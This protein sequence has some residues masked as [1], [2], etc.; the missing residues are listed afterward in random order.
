MEPETKSRPPYSEHHT[1]WKTGRGS[2]LTDSESARSK[3]VVMTYG[4]VHALHAQLWSE[5]TTLLHVHHGITGSEGTLRN[6]FPV[7]LP[8]Q[9]PVSLSV[10]VTLLYPITTVV[11]A[12]SRWLENEVWNSSHFWRVLDSVCRI[13]RSSKTLNFLKFHKGHRLF[14]ES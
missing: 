4:T 8:V 2:S 6:Q 13:G 10:V 11:S 5:F 12:Y 9:I 7:D 14:V 1:R 3:E